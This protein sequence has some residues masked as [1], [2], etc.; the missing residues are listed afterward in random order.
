[1][2][3]RLAPSM[4]P[5]ATATYCNPA[6]AIRKGAARHAGHGGCAPTRPPARPGTRA[7]PGEQRAEDHLVG[8]DDDL[9]LDNGLG[10]YNGLRQLLAHHDVLRGPITGPH[11][12]PIPPT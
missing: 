7:Q 12:V 1:M 2:K 8:L 11:S 4:A 5:T 10:L 3:R 9:G 6:E